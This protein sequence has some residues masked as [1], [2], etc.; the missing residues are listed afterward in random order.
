MSIL[1]IV[2]SFFSK[3]KKR[4]RKFLSADNRWNKTKRES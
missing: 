3:K 1:I 2:W 4:N